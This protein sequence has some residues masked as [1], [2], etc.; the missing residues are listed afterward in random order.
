M[1]VFRRSRQDEPEEVTEVLDQQDVRIVSDDPEPPRIGRIHPGRRHVLATD[2]TR[3][4]RSVVADA[5]ELGPAWLAAVSVVG[6]RHADKPGQ[7]RQDRYA[8]T[9]LGNFVAVAVADGV[10]DARDSAFGARVAANAA[11]QGATGLPERR[12]LELFDP[13]H[14][15]SGRAARTLREVVAEA[16]AAVVG[17][18]KTDPRTRAT[19]LVLAVAAPAGEDTLT[20]ATARV[21]DSSAYLMEAQGVRPVFPP[22]GRGRALRHALPLRGGAEDAV[23]TAFVHARPGTPFV[24]ATDGVT[25]DLES[26]SEVRDWISS[27]LRAGNPGALDLHR[28]IAYERQGSADDRTLLSIHAR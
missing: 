27:I 10:S 2:S 25:K 12:L 5:G 11:C 28:L 22:G 24:L 20:I 23:E 1:S 6:A 9:A 16:D 13:A 14:Q 21:G 4:G 19:T 15:A 26:S 7:E 3:V 18:A 17:S 8:F